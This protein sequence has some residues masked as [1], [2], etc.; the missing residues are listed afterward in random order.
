[1][2]RTPTGQVVERTGKNGR[3]FAL[4]FRAEGRR[5]YLTLGSSAEGWTRRMAEEKLADVVAE[6]RLG[7]WRPP[8][9][10]SGQREPS[11]PSFHEFASRWFEARKDEWR[12]STRLDYEWQLSQHLLPFFARHRLSEITVAEVDRYRAAKLREGRLSGTSINK[13]IT[14]LAQI[15]E[16]AVE[17]DWIA[18]NPA[19]GKRRRVKAPTPTRTW[20]DRAEQIAALLGAAGEFDREA[21]ID[22]PRH[23]RAFLATLVFSGLRIGEALALRWRDVELAAGRIRVAGSKTDAGARHVDLLPP[24]RDELAAHKA[25]FGDVPTEALVFGTSSGRPDNRNNARRRIF[26]RAVERANQR[27][28]EADRDPLPERLTPHSLRRTYASLLVASGED[29]A[30]VMEQLG[31]TD[32]KLTL[33]IYAHTMRRKDGERERLH[34]LVTGKSW[35]RL[36]T[37]AQSTP[38]PPAHRADPKKPKTPRTRGLPSDGRGWVRTSDLSRVRRALSH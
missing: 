17:Y 8:D 38:K 32:A 18:R 29:P 1:M 37:G 16:D 23:R 3:T 36:G 7:L 4:R 13:T 24:L 19:R 15:L 33:R 22:R 28:A 6:V 9:P 27:L 25:R 5:R 30:Y 14:R 2:P 34:A 21:R 10:E 35:P 12:K 26:G 31:H 11:E 20:L